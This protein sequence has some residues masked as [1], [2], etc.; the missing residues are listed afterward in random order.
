MRVK[1]LYVAPETEVQELKSETIICMSGSI[2][3]LQEEEITW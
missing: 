1:E 2:T 3:E